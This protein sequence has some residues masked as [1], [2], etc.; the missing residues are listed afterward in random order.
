M[1]KFI[2][3]FSFLFSGCSYFEFNAA[4]CDKVGSEQTPEMIEKCRNYKEE[5]AEKA[6]NKTKIKSSSELEDALEFKK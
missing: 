3:V 5:E 1:W 2:L 6:F 4:M